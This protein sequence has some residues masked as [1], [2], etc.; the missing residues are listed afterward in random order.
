M[1]SLQFSLIP[2]FGWETAHCNANEAYYQL[3]LPAIQAEARLKACKEVTKYYPK[4]GSLALMYAS[5]LFEGHRQR[6]EQ[7]LSLLSRTS[8]YVERNIKKIMGYPPFFGSV[9]GYYQLKKVLAAPVTQLPNKHHHVLRHVIELTSL[10]L[11]LVPVDL[12]V[13]LYRM[14]C[15]KRHYD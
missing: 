8:S 3:S 5:T 1:S 10:G 9:H 15:M 4:G 7:E 2:A 6:I 14:R 12:C 13:T 11:V